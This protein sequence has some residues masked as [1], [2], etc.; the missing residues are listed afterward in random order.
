MVQEWRVCFN[1]K[2]IWSHCMLAFYHLRLQSMHTKVVTPAL[3]VR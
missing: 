1:L 2:N 3:S